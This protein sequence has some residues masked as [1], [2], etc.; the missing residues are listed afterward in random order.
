MDTST[1]QLIGNIREFLKH[2]SWKQVTVK[3]DGL[4]C[5]ETGEAVMGRSSTANNV[6]TLPS[7]REIFMTVEER[8]FW[9]CTTDAVR[10]MPTAK[11]ITF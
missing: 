8:W 7:V 5:E 3:D 2:C 4:G 11:M 1:K 6:C 10:P 9:T